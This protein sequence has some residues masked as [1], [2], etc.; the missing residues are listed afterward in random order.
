MQDKN[1]IDKEDPD[2][3]VL[4]KELDGLPLALFTTG[5]YLEHVTTSFLDYLR[6]YQ[7]S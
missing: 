3:L 6:L 1:Y 5:V 4:I 2:I 7:V